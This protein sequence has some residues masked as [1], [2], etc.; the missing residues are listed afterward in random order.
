MAVGYN[1]KIVTDSLVLALDAAN[2]KS[3]GSSGATWQDMCG[4]GNNGTLTGPLHSQGPFPGAG[5]V[6]FDGQGNHSQLDVIHTSS[7]SADFDL[8]GNISS[9]VECWV[10]LTAYPGTTQNSDNPHWGGA[11]IF[12]IKNHATNFGKYYFYTINTS[13]QLEMI[14]DYGSGFPSTGTSTSTLSLNTWYH[15][16]WVR[17]SGSNKF[18]LDGTEIT[19]EFSTPNASN[20]IGSGNS[21]ISIGAD[22]YQSS[23]LNWLR[24]ITGYISNFRV[25]NGTALYTSNFT[26]PKKPLQNISN[27]K[28]LTCQGSSITDASS[29]AQ[30]LSSNGGPTAT[31]NDDPYFDFDGSNDTI[32]L[33]TQINS[34]ITE[35]DITVSFWT[36]L[37]S[38]SG[39]RAFVAMSSVATGVPL[40]IWHDASVSSRDNTGTGDVGGGTTNA[41]VVMV[42]DT[43]GSKRFST[44]NNALSASTWHN[45][46]VVLDVTNNAFYTYIDGVEEAKYVSTNT[47]LGLKSS[48]NNFIIGGAALAYLDGRISN[49]NV[50]TKA[51]TAAEVKQNYDALKGR[52]A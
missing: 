43:N 33:G 20:M 26:V 12:S 7:L 6:F 46:S 16:A 22:F 3:W 4:K 34:D 39:D 38:T 8:S 49:F 23:T 31:Y 18:F 29:S 24:P 15:I 9:T 17:D 52:Y 32:S 13:G 36:Y 1:P 21:K 41:I 42:S 37:D 48:N 44:S 28:L 2:L 10:Y 51:L 30:T 45:V 5:S 25:V 27:T 47:S 40:I 14:G 19:S 50:Y 11:T 35:T